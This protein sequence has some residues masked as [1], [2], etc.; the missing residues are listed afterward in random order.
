MRL[1]AL[2]TAGVIVAATACAA[3][4]AA[5]PPSTLPPVE[6]SA[7]TTSTSSTSSTT[8]TV[9]KVDLLGKAR[10]AVVRVRNVVCLATGTAFILDTGQTI[11][12]R[13]VAAES[14]RVQLST[15]DGTD[16]VG[17]VASVSSDHD[18]AALT[19]PTSRTGLHL[20]ATD[21]TPGQTVWVAGYPLGDQLDLRQG[22]II[23]ADPG[24]G[25]AGGV[26]RA[27]VNIEPGNSGSPV[28]NQAGEVVAVAFATQTSTNDALFIPAS[29][30][31]DLLNGN[32]PTTAAP[33]CD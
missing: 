4:P 31:R 25:E 3:A 6:T 2:L 12:N 33:G 1:R 19:V 29:H 21:P 14:R 32:D 27:S 8:T 13:H 9:A 5:A 11:T 15:W 26:I 24:H 22:T 7:P 17:S 10:S 16:L 30:L 23:D 20:S 28:L 18:L